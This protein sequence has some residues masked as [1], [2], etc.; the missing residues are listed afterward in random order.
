MMMILGMMVFERR[1]LPYQTM[2]RNSDYRWASGSRIGTR[3]TLQFLGAGEE[4]IKLSGELRPEIT[5]GVISLFVLEQMAQQGR[6]WPLLGGNG[7]PYGMFV[8]ASMNGT[9]TDFLQNGSARKITFD[10]TLKRVD[11]N[12]VSM[13][14]DLKQQAEDMI[15]QVGKKASQLM[16]SL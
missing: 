7:I 2:T 16:G 6:A 14:G 15:N 12:L 10:I 3:P 5:G 4:S 13:F 9:Y 8:I 11:E 1:T